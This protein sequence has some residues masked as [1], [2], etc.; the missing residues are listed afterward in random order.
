MAAGEGVVAA[1]VDAV[2]GRLSWDPAFKVCFMTIPKRRDSL[3]RFSAIPIYLGSRQ[4]LYNH[5]STLETIW[6]IELLA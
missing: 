5:R 3:Q 4:S 6:G 1:V 2:D